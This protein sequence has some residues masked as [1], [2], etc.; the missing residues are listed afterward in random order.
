MLEIQFNWIFILIAGAVILAFFFSIVQKQQSLSQEKLSITLIGQLDTIATGALAAKGAAQPVGLPKTGIDF[1]CSEE[2]SCG[3]TIGTITRDYGDKILFAPKHVEGK[4]ITFWT[5]PWNIPYH[6]ANFLFATNDRIKYFFVYDQSGGSQQLKDKL[7]PA[8][9]KDDTGQVQVNA[10][11]ITLDEL[12]CATNSQCVKNENYLEVK[13]VFLEVVPPTNFDGS[14]G[15]RLDTSF[16]DTDVTAVYIT[17]GSATFYQRQ[18]KSATTF[19]PTSLYYAGDASLFGAIFAHDAATYD[20]QMR[21]AAKRLASVTRIL[22]QRMQTLRDDPTLA[23]RGCSYSP[24]NLNLLASQADSQIGGMTQDL[25]AIS[26]TAQQI[27]QEN[28]ALLRQSCPTL[29]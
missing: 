21:E 13:L 6:A 2:C 14:A 15:V 10:Q 1:A 26:G 22:T 18:G 20:C 25:T 11:F 5:L 8:L 7:S 9:P 17:T 23:D 12:N 27:T 24:Q 4:T 29:Y 3:F 16:K 28:E 19:T